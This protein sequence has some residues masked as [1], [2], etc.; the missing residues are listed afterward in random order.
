[1]YFYNIFCEKNVEKL[2]ETASEAPDKPHSHQNAYYLGIIF[3]NDI[4]ALFIF[5]F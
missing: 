3:F 2:F 4:K 1:M 5:Y